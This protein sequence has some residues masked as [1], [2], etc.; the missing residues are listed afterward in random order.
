MLGCD[1]NNFTCWSIV[2]HVFF[3]VAHGKAKKNFVLGLMQAMG[4]GAI[5]AAGPA[6]VVADENGRYHNLRQLNLSI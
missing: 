6:E 1:A 3:G 2:H 4:S 5:I